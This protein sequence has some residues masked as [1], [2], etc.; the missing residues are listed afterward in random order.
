[1]SFKQLLG[2][3]LIIA[4]GGLGTQLQEAGL[5]PGEAPILWN[6]THP[7]EVRSIHQNYLRAGSTL[8]TTNTFSAG[9]IMLGGDASMALEAVER[10][11]HLAREAIEKQGSDAFVAL[12]VG[13]LGRM[14]KPLGDVPFEHALE[15]FTQQVESGASAGAD[16]VLI[17]T[18]FDTYEIK[19][20]VLAARQ[21]CQLPVLATV[22]LD[23]RGRM[24][25]GADSA[26]ICALLEGLGVDALGMNCGGG[27]EEAAPFI[28]EFRNY[29]SLPLILNPNA[30]LPITEHDFTT[31]PVGPDEFAALMEPLVRE[32]V[33]VAGGCCG[34]TPEHIKALAECCSGVVPKEI[35]K[36]SRRLVSSY[37]QTV[38]L[39][40]AELNIDRR[41]G[42]VINSSFAAAL[43]DEDY[44]FAVDEALEARDDEAQIIALTAACPDIDE[45][46]VLSLLIE[47]I[48][49]RVRLPLALIT[50]NLV[51]L[52]RA[53]RAYN[54]CPLVSLELLDPAQRQE[55][56]TLAT[57]YGA[58]I[59]DK[60]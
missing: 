35:T 55:A 24:L 46:E 14:L 30:G 37:S 50:G 33:A 41:L 48:Q 49:T 9:A 12:D 29:S 20:A 60:L 47:E 8:I 7:D 54:G 15:I 56:E 26:C 2:K 45:A 11:V 3:Q 21:A 58:I 42:P 44:S 59:L 32:Y 19:A 22:T 18:M 16:L 6:I 28:E 4:D 43:Q 13:P 31:Y 1:M 38:D 57:R 17:E 36:T 39:E 40:G 25:N 34:T 5:A 52:E 51:A 27:P 23:V 53:L 10:G